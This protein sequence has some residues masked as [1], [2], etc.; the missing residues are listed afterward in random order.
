LLRR[1]KGTEKKKHPIALQ[2]NANALPTFCQRFA[3]V[4]P[5]F[6]QRFAKMTIS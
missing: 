6:C 2:R 3:N 1:C 5:T 4:L